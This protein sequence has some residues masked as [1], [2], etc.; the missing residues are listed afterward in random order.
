MPMFVSVYKNRKH[1]LYIYFFIRFS[2]DC[3]LHVT[4][5]LQTTKTPQVVNDFQI[6]RLNRNIIIIYF[7]FYGQAEN[8]FSDQNVYM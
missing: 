5:K 1:C 2:F 3:V 6:N 7:T 4:L 8:F